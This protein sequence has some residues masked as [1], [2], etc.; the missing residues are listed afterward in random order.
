[1]FREYTKSLFKRV[2]KRQLMQFKPPRLPQRIYTKTL[3]IDNKHY[4]KFCQEVAWP[5]SEHVHPLYLQMLSLP[6]QM[7][8]LLDKQSPF[9]LLGLI[10]CA[11]KVEVFEHCDLSE[12]VECRVRFSD[13]RPHARGWEVD[14][15]LDALQSSKCVYK[16][17]S[18]YLVKVKAVHVAPRAAQTEHVSTDESD[19]AIQRELVSSLTASA[20]TGRRYAAISGDYN[21]IHLSAVS[22]K[23]FG[24]KTAIAHGMWTLACVISQFVDNTA[25]KT[26]VDDIVEANGESTDNAEKEQGSGGDKALCNGY[27]KEVSCRF[28]QPVYLPNELTVFSKSLTSSLSATSESHANPCANHSPKHSAELEVTS[29]KDST[30]HLHAFLHY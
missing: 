6:L 28:K 14:V 4:G 18:S 10:H 20:D 17:V 5:A 22:A 16:A 12:P 8:C 30:T 27:I 19:E 11:N 21:P 23:A 9:P 24:F 2:D 29:A 13:V 3:N 7:R 15:L 1:M 25:D 26:T